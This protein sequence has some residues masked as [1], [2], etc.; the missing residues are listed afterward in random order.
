MAS[1]FDR[2]LLVVSG[3]GGVGKTTLAAA[4]G[5]LAA[6]RGLRTI[7]VEVGEQARLP[8]LFQDSA[9]AP[10][11]SPQAGVE[12][13]L[14]P[15]LWSLSLDPDRALLEWLQSLGGR[16]SGRVLASSGTFQYF[17]AAAPGARELVSMVK[18]W[19]L[20]RGRRRRGRGHG[21]DLVVLDAPATGHA[22]GLLDSPR[23]FGA[24]ARV[25]PIA[26][27]A[28]RLR[29]LLED[30]ERSDYLAVAQ[31]TEL[32]VTETLELQERLNEQLGRDLR[33]VIVNG[34]LPQR[35]NAP[36]LRALEELLAGPAD[37]AITPRARA[38]STG[39]GG[40]DSRAGSRPA[41]ETKLIGSALAAAEAVSERAR[42][43]HNQLSRLRRRKFEVV[44][45]PFQF[46]AA[47]DLAAVR[48]IADQ[49]KRKL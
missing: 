37:P 20:T 38:G 2:E 15:E 6:D 49:L 24:I 8:A 43:Q 10:E 16:V 27:Q 11:E 1:V 13:Q 45:V 39:A 35:F 5:M 29:E 23:T 17:A 44:G 34:M 30:P 42:S 22:L 18:I 25:G 4:L 41:A 14:A 46:S 48:R 31:G 3:K 36:E 9:R 7:V 40:S 47:L 19:E 12:T 21:Y 28:E 33:M 26:A 32:A